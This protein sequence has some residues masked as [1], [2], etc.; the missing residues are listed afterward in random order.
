[1][2][3]RKSLNLA[4]WNCFKVMLGETMKPVD[5]CAVVYGD[6]IHLQQCRWSVSSRGFHKVADVQFLHNL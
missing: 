6:Y 4:P 1:M 5:V 2:L 3:V